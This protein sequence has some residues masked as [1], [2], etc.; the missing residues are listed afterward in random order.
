MKRRKPKMPKRRVHFNM[1]TG[2]RPHG[3]VK[4]NTMSAEEAIEEQMEA[5]LQ[6]LENIELEYEENEY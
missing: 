1:P 6:E 3:R 2:T 4:A 5:Y